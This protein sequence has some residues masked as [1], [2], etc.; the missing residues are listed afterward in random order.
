MKTLLE[1]DRL[2]LIPIDVRSPAHR[3]LYV[4]LHTD[5]AV[6]HQVSSPLSPQ[7]A[8]V[9]FE[10]F[11][12]STRG[13]H[14]GHRYWIVV[15]TASAAAIG[16]VG[17]QK[18]GRGAEIGVMVLPGWWQRGVATEALTCLLEYGR[19]TLG[20]NAVSAQSLEGH[21]PV[22]GALFR[23]LGFRTVPGPPG[24]RGWE[25]SPLH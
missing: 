19:R 2:Q 6:M 20:L 3:A 4:D 14:P 10:R 17:F 5:P 13:E 12:A 8:E 11:C 1:T 21:A 18:L 23:R 24:R 16:L 15:D 7:A 9:A 25:A 22:M